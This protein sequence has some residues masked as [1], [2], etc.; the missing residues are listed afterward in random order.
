[1]ILLWMLLSIPDIEIEYEDFLL[2]ARETMWT[3][4]DQAALRQ[5]MENLV[6]HDQHMWVG[7][8]SSS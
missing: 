3:A 1:M 5:N 4:L 8:S 2:R 6:H 7:S